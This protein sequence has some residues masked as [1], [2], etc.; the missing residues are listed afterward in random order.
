M[1]LAAYC[2]FFERGHVK[3]VTFE[4]LTKEPAETI[5]A[6]Y[7]WLGAGSS[8]IEPNITEAEHTTPNIVSMAAGFGLLRRLRQSRPVRPL[9]PVVPNPIRRVGAR[10]ATK[11][12]DRHSVDTSQVIQFLR[13]L[14]TKQTEELSQLLDRKFPEWTTLFEN[15]AA[16]K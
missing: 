6:I 5:D 11:N 13:P 4:E 16:D 3:A 9:I 1:Q 7:R 2:E 14:Q 12:V 8:P 15:A 10:L